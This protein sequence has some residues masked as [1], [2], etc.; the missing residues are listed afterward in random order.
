M[1]MNVIEVAIYAMVLTSSQPAPFDCVAVRPSGVNCTN[2]LAATAPTPN[3]IAFSNGVQVI[4]DNQGRVRLSNGM[5]TLYDSAA[6]VSFKDA[7]GNTAISVR[8]TNTFR[9]R[10]SNGYTCEAKGEAPD[11]ARCEPR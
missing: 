6:W 8:K 10:F 5:T 2:G 1:P 11:A 4:K 7:A 3:V 9:F